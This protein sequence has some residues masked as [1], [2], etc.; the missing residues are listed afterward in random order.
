M[1]LTIEDP[2]ADRL[3]RAVADRTGETLAQAVINAL[4]DRLAREE[5]AQD[6]IESRV[7]DA[8]EIGRHCASLPTLDR[9]IPEKILEYDE[10]GL[11]R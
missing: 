2:E 8:M 4:R 11:P 6:D 3:A 7:A 1:A 5:R 10:N 9:R